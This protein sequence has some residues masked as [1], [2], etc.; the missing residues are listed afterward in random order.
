MVVLQQRKKKRSAS[1]NYIDL[2]I[3]SGTSK[4]KEKQ[5]FTY[6]MGLLA[7]GLGTFLLT[8]TSF[9][10][11]FLLLTRK[12]FINQPRSNKPETNQ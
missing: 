2:L 4:N 9:G 5:F 6:L 10:R 7:L 1:E 11:P 8:I 3:E 12:F